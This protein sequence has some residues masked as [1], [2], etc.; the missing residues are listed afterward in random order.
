LIW[1]FKKTK[2]RGLLTK[3]KNYTTLLKTFIDCILI[4]VHSVQT[5][6]H[7]G[8]GSA[9]PRTEGSLILKMFKNLELRYFHSEDSKN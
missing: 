1:K 3:S 4:T 8:E 7:S 9:K 5:V 6:F 2:T